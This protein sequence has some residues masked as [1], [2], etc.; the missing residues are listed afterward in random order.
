MWSAGQ[1]DVPS[2][3]VLTDAKVRK[4]AVR[5]C[6]HITE[7]ATMITDVCRGH[8]WPPLSENIK[9]CGRN[10]VV[11]TFSFISVCLFLRGSG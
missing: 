7:K 4:D 11:R 3:H 5:V 8:V 9:R 6:I 10:R 1:Q 2:V